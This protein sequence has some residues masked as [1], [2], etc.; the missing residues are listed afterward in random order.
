M[1]ATASDAQPPRRAARVLPLLRRP[2]SRA[3]CVDGP[4]PCPWVSCRHHGLWLRGQ[5]E[6][7]GLDD[8]QLVELVEQ[9]PYSCGLDAADEAEGDGGWTL[10]QAGSVIG[11]TRERARQ[12]ETSAMAKLRLPVALALGRMAGDVGDVWEGDLS[13]TW[14][15]LGDG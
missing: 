10:A 9:L 3:E 15:G 1:T 2:R 11:A 5:Q 4:R 7:R 13:S 6:R 14:D 12:L 8:D